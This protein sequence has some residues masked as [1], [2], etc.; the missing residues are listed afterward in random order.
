MSERRRARANGGM[1]EPDEDEVP[2]WLFRFQYGQWAVGGTP[3]SPVQKPLPTSAREMVEYCRARRRWHEMREKWLKAN[4]WIM[5]DVYPDRHEEYQE[6]AEREPA[7]VLKPDWAAESED[8]RTRGRLLQY[9][10]EESAAV[11]G[12]RG[13]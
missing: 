5:Q 3:E 7:R 8:F 2:A 10:T 6:Q 13:W 4:G 1:S 11:L 12:S 9:A